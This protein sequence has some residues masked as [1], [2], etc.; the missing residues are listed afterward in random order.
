[1]QRHC[2][3]QRLRAPNVFGETVCNGPPEHDVV[4]EDD[5]EEDQ[6]EHEL[7]RLNR[8]NRRLHALLELRNQFSDRRLYVDSLHVSNF[9]H[10]R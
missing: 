8:F 9:T 4:Q 2:R 3:K 6:E 10:N 5:H 1:M 7:N